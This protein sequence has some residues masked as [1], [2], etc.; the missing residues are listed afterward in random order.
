MTGQKKIF[1]RKKLLVAVKQLKRGGKIIV[2]TNGVFDL[3]HVGHVRYLAEAKKLGDVLV[4]AVNSDRSTR[5]LKGPTRPLN[6]ARDRAELLAALACVDFV[7]IFN[8][9]DP[10]ALLKAIKPHVHVKG[11][12]Y[13]LKDLPEREVVENNGGKIVLVKPSRGYSTSAIIERIDLLHNPLRREIS[14][15]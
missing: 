13:K 3:L 14:G 1:T 7:T 10:R 5:A 6:R 15:F 2:T 11:G 8:E 9:R 12:D 4:V